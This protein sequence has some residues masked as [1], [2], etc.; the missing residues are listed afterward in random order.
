M[1][2]H[3]N[4]DHKKEKSRKLNEEQCMRLSIHMSWD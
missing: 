2:N 4:E 1:Y 3:I